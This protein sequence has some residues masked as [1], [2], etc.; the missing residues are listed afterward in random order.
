MDFEAAHKSTL[1]RVDSQGYDP[2]HQKRLIYLSALSITVIVSGYLLKYFIN[3]VLARYLKAEVYG[4]F[5]FFINVVTFGAGILMLGADDAVLC[6]IPG[7]MAGRSLRKISGYF[8]REV[9]LLE[10]AIL[11]AVY[12]AAIIF[13]LIFVIDSWVHKS[14]TLDYNL[15]LFGIWIVPLYGLVNFQAKTLRS[16]GSINWS[17][18]SFWFAPILLFSGGILII[19]ALFGKIDIYQI[20]LIYGFSLLFVAVQQALVIFSIVPKKILNISPVYA[21]KKWLRVSLQLFF[22]SLINTGTSSIA[23]ILLEIIAPGEVEVGIFGAIL[24][25]CASL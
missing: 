2:H 9:K 13:S 21:N 15:I 8:R 20:L 3:L 6:F 11:I 16:F 10:I 18:F 5:S 23:I 14:P 19:L 24:T 4:N 7:Y 1:E 25:I 12:I 17:L 22:S